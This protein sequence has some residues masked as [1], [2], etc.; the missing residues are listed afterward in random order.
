MKFVFD[1]F[2][3]ENLIASFALAVASISLILNLSDRIQRR[4]KFCIENI[5]VYTM[6][7][8]RTDSHIL[9]SFSLRNASS[10]PL[11]LER[12]YIRLNK[13][14]AIPCLSQ[15]ECVRTLQGIHPANQTDRF[16]AASSMSLPV[17][18]PAHAAVQTETLFCLK[19]PQRSVDLLE[20]RLSEP[21]RPCSLFQTFLRHSKASCASLDL[22]LSVHGR[23]F[24]R[25]VER[26]MVDF[27][28]SADIDDA[29]ISQI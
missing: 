2:D 11:S 8:G 12:L 26:G 6:S 25:S 21:S 18:V 7:I 1:V 22:I 23:S 19:P 15:V 9:L 10:R 20:F 14:D 29:Q 13:S 4:T 17:V 16:L 5:R 27:V 3:T 24:H 28:D